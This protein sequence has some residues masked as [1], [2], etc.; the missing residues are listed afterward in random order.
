M[1]NPRQGPDYEF[2]GTNNPQI[3]L[4]T[5]LQ[6]CVT[7]AQT[8]WICRGGSFPTESTSPLLRE[9]Y[10][11]LRRTCWSVNPKNYCKQRIP[12]CRRPYLLGITT[13]SNFSTE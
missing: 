7:T 5:G 10:F 3:I 13:V 11:H 8:L 6:N 1:Y 9:Q 4:L 12:T 2:L